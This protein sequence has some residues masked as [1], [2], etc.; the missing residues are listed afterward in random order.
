MNNCVVTDKP[1]PIMMTLK[2]ASAYT[3]LTYEALRCLCLQKKIVFVRVGK[4][5]LVNRI[6]LEQYLDT[7]DAEGVHYGS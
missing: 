6:K 1:M 2:E 7:G 4:K 5:Y 3:G